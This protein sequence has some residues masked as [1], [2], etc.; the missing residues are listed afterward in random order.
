ME[1]GFCSVVFNRYIHKTDRIPVNYWM[2][3]LRCALVSVGREVCHNRFGKVT[4]PF[5]QVSENTRQCGTMLKV[6][7]MASHLTGTPC[8][9]GPI[10]WVR[11][12]GKKVSHRDAPTCN[13]SL[14]NIDYQCLNSILKS[15]FLVPY[16]NKCSDRSMEVKLW[17]TDLRTDGR[18]GSYTSNI[19][20]VQVPHNRRSIKIFQIDF[21]HFFTCLIIDD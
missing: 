18:T 10:D 5:H 8:M 9:M 20:K 6:Y 12:W 14:L 4:L 17:Q 3:N 1:Y 13:K 21:P 7:V 16:E 2:C 15:E 11:M 19:W